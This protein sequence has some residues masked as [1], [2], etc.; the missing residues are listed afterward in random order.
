MLLVPTVLGVVNKGSPTFKL[1]D[2]DFNMVELMDTTKL[3]QS[4]IYSEIRNVIVN[5]RSKNF[6]NGNLLRARLGQ[7]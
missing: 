4:K 3:L 7:N 2:P 5:Y 6:I 1:I